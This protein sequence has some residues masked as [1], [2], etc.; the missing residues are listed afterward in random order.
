MFTSSAN[1]GA[2]VKEH[3]SVTLI[4]YNDTSIIKQLSNQALEPSS[5]FWL[6]K[7]FTFQL[8]GTT[9]VTKGENHVGE[10]RGSDEKA[11]SYGKRRLSKDSGLSHPPTSPNDDHSQKRRKGDNHGSQS[12][13]QGEKNSALGDLVKESRLDR[14]NAR[15]SRRA[16]GIG[17]SDVKSLQIKKQAPR[18]QPKDDLQAAKKNSDNFENDKRS[19]KTPRC[20]VTSS[21]GYDKQDRDHPPNSNDDGEDSDED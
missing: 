16:G 12:E 10:R 7:P 14:L 6:I 20:Q 9:I 1:Q 19:D 5:L 18:V 4:S 17:L 8:S 11:T 2:S 3:R 15:N 13:T 21:K